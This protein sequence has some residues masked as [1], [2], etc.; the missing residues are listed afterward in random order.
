MFHI[1]LTA[2]VRKYTWHNNIKVR[3]Q[4]TNDRPRTN[5]SSNKN[6]AN[7]QQCVFIGEKKEQKRKE[8]EKAVV[9]R[10]KDEEE[11]SNVMYCLKVC[12][13]VLFLS[14]CYCLYTLRSLACLLVYILK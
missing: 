6:W 4:Q 7:T 11:K 8:G 5:D 13:R 3:E 1:K 10:E 2:S 14:L 12:V 9:K